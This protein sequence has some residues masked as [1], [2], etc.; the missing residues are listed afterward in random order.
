MTSDDKRR[1]VFIAPLPPPFGG[2]ANWTRIVVDGIKKNL[3]WQV[4]IADTAPRKRATEGRVLSDRILDGLFSTY[5]TIRF[6]KQ[7]CKSNIPQ[8]VHVATSG[9]LALFR[10]RVILKYL[11]KHNIPSVYHLHFGRVPEIL[12]GVSWEK[13]I[14]LKNL[15]LCSRLIVIDGFTRDAL[16]DVS[17]SG[18]VRYIE[19]PI[20]IDALLAISQGDAIEH[21]TVIYIGWI[22]PSK[23]IAELCQAWKGIYKKHPDWRLELVGPYDSQAVESLVGDCSIG[24]DLMGEL[25]HDQAMRRLS[26]SAIAVLPSHTEGFPNFVL[27][28]MALG[29]P[30]VGTDVGA[31]PEM[32]DD[33]R[34]LVVPSRDVGALEHAVERLIVC[35]EER[36]EMGISALQY[37]EEHCAVDRV[38]SRYEGAWLEAM[39]L[40]AE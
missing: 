24:I 38:I 3:N 22:V 5:R 32:L 18:K 40:S 33:G 11:L 8:V 13:R 12:K 39:S 17:D 31:I 27:E 28:A 26:Q 15:K 16:C 9:S 20:D 2:I 14:L 4:A 19:N 23:G 37:V 29:K 36:L 35:K 6:L 7:E 25:P 34:G 1:I 30:V 21:K 10:D